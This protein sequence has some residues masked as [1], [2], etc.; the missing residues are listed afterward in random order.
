[1]IHGDQD[2][3][4]PVQQS[5][6]WAAKMKELKLMYEYREIKGA[7]HSDAM[8]SVA[9]DMFRFFDSHRARTSVGRHNPQP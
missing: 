5:R 3:A 2:N 9:R 8:V 7:G 4:V 1:M 6:D